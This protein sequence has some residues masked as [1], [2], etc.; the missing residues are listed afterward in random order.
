[1]SND[2]K[3]HEFEIEKVTTIDRFS[4]ITK[5]LFLLSILC[6]VIFVVI[7]MGTYIWNYG[8]NWAI[9]SFSSWVLILSALILFF[10]L[11]EIIIYYKLGKLD[12]KIRLAEIPKP[13]FVNGKRV[14]QFTFPKGSEGGIFSKTYIKI[15]QHNILRLRLL[16]VKPGELWS[17]FKEVKENE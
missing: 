15:D 13:E 12:E 1:M 17:T 4:L 8:H 9:I 16:M 10:I 3:N 6:V 11:V 2:E 5:I 7:F 14:H